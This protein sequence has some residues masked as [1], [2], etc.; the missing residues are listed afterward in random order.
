VWS[1]SPEDLPSLKIISDNAYQMAR[2]AG[3]PEKN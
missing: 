2:L 1:A 3:K